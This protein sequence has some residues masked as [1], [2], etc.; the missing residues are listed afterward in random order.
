[1]IDH[2]NHLLWQRLTLTKQDEPVIMSQLVFNVGL[3][4]NYCPLLGAALILLF[5]HA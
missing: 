4:L 5:L 3:N 2:K 1:M